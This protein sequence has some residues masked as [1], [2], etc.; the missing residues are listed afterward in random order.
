MSMQD[1][2]KAFLGFGALAAVLIV[3]VII[4]WPPPYF[5]KTEATGAIGA[6][7]KHREPQIT[8]QDVVLG[9][10]ATRREQQVVF[11]HYLNDAA[12][13]HA[14]S[15]ELAARSEARSRAQAAARELASMNAEM[16]VRFA[17]NVDFAVAA[18]EQLLAR[19]ANL[20]ARLASE[21][22]DIGA[23]AKASQLASEDFQALSARLKNV[24]EQLA[25]APC[26]SGRG[27]MDAR[28]LASAEQMMAKA[29]APL[30]AKALSNEALVAAAADVDNG[31]RALNARFAAANY[32]DFVEYLNDFALQARA[33]ANA[34]EQ[35]AVAAQLQNEEQV[36]A[37]LYDVS[38]ALA[39]QA[40]NLES[41]A[42]RNLDE[43][44]ASDA[45]LALRLRNIDEAMAASNRA[46]A[47]RAS[48]L[49][50]DSMQ[51]FN[52]A[53][54]NF[55]EAMA[56]RSREFQARA[57]ANIESQMA[58]FDSYLNAR[59]QVHARVLNVRP[60]YA[61]KLANLDSIEAHMANLD[62]ALSARAP[63]A[64]YVANYE[65]LEGRARDLKNRAARNLN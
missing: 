49:R 38:E 54:Q 7:Q 58:S 36:A 29:A 39:A 32:A 24:A 44:L 3:A 22:A 13:L 27:Q 52:R 50:N 55:G 46:V 53:M 20:H 65:Q 6:V 31:V 30:Q 21:F 18:M 51:S 14:V 8:P 19:D 37:R 4:T 60:A 25:I 12:K 47:N 23:R 11:A 16:Q 1:R 34:E 57:A 5:N 56:S 2:R 33:M 45:A 43:Q 26:C 15:A 64:A 40:F 61:A 17:Q 9:D 59:K 28:N 10:E 48:M 35:L 63:L 42:I 62:Q 41:R